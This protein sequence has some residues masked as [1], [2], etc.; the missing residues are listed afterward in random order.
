[1]SDTWT[2]TP[3]DAATPSA[4]RDHAAVWT[5]SEMIVWGGSIWVNTGLGA[6]YAFILPKHRSGNNFFIESVHDGGAVD[7]F[8]PVTK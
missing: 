2:P 4:R 5:G 1:M 3:I 6:A 8:G 7:R